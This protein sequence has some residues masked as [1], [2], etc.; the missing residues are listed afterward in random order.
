MNRCKGSGS[1][2]DA[3]AIQKPTAKPLSQDLF[4]QPLNSQKWFQEE[5]DNQATA[6]MIPQNE[7]TLLNKNGKFSH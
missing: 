2:F 5:T 4:S 6:E 1:P 3:N 7:N